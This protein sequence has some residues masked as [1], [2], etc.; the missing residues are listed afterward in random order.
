M[1]DMIMEILGHAGLN[2]G[3]DAAGAIISNP[4]RRQARA[5]DLGQTGIF[6]SSRERKRRKLAAQQPVRSRGTKNHTHG[7]DSIDGLRVGEG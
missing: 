5:R 6:N 3:T 7:K 1:M 4:S 2:E